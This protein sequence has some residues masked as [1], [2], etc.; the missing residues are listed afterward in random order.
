MNRTKPINQFADIFLNREYHSY[1]QNHARQGVSS[2]MHFL[3]RRQFLKQNTSA[4]SRQRHDVQQ[5]V[6]A[7]TTQFNSV[8]MVERWAVRTLMALSL[9]SP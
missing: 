5:Y 4:V 6:S 9:L 3:P 8:V 1:V 7:A 2:A